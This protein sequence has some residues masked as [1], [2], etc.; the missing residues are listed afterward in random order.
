MMQT[1]APLDEVYRVIHTDHYD[2][3][4]VLGLHLV[5]H[6]GK[7]IAAIRAFL[8]DARDA[9]VIDLETPNSPKEYA[10]TKVHDYGFFEV[11]VPSKSAPFYYQ[12]RTVD[13]AGDVQ[14]FHDSYAFMP[15]LTEFDLHLFGEGTHY[16]IYEK[17]GAHYAEV[18]GI[19]GVQFAVWAPSARSV[20][21]IG[22]FNRW[23]RR[24]HAMRML[25][26]S[27]VWEIFIPG[28]PEG[29]LYKFQIK[30]QQGFIMD[31]T[32]PYARAMET[33]PRTASVVNFLD[34]HEWHDAKWMERRAKTSWLEQPI[35]AY[36]VHLG[37]W[38]RM[39]EEGNRQLRY[40]EAAKEL[41]DYVKAMG[42]THIQL[43]PVM[44][45]PF[46][47]SWG[48]QVTG[49]FAPTSRFG[50][51]E[52][53]MFFMDYCHQN[54]IGVLLDWVPAHFPKDVH[55]LGRFDGTALYE[56]ADPRQGE[57]QDWGTLIF[58]YGRNEVRNFLI[59]NALFWL[60]KYHIDGLRID[61]VAS[62]LYLDYSRKAGEW[63]PNRY[64]GRE[65]LDAIEFLKHLNSV[66]HEKFSG[67]LTIAEESTAWPGVTTPVYY[68]GLGFDLKWNMGWMHDMLE[69]FSKDSIYRKF[70]HNNLTF[71]LLYAFTERFLL[72]LS[73]DEVVHGKRSLLS[74][75]PGDVWQQ[76]ANLRLLYGLMY[77]FPGKKLLFMGGEFGQWLEWNHDRSLDWH[78]LSY[79]THAR[80]QQW[81]RDLNML[82]RSEPALHEIDFHYS[83]FE[84]ID[85]HDTEGSVIS[86]LRKGK[87]PYDVIVVVCNFTPVPRWN[88]RIGAPAGGAYREILNSDS[89][90][91]GGSNLGNGGAIMAEAIPHHNQRHSLSLTLPPLAVVVLKRER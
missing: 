87:N 36:E 78:L 11:L 52:D 85:F 17:L 55:A 75:M 61:A 79:E 10:M 68:G 26:S 34:K 42:Y 22:S 16:N 47:G 63:V 30:T 28:L 82:Y 21:V 12:L 41:V 6:H 83:G 13:W 19:G 77:G 76:F 65:N 86:F 7:T 90:Y 23:D 37:S 74:K 32:D 44:E 46:D 60:E 38:R 24:K 59:G 91:Y 9:F 48:Y 84:W 40:R 1:T 72:P 89:V 88:Y 35:A 56:H 53:F 2:P 18:N 33:R 15:T 73:H 80:L 50:P 43:L 4:R 3:F 27:G 25:G 67:V 5:E 70:H 29:E 62:M 58:N 54:N 64:G 51:P 49:Y 69:Y 14:T 71:A 45:H 39:P 81:V 66:V 20:S 31:K 8:P 57:H